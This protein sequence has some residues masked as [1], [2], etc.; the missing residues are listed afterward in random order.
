M[1]EPEGDLE[2]KVEQGGKRSFFNRIHGD[3][4][5]IVAAILLAMATVASAWSACQASRW[6]GVEAKKYN[7]ANARRVEASTYADDAEQEYGL[8]SDMFIYYSYELYNGNESAVKYFE[9]VLFRDEMRTAVLAWKKLKPWEN[10]EAPE[11]PMDMP[12]YKSDHEA[13]SLKLFGEADE[14][15]N[16]ARKAINHSDTYVTLTVLF[17]SVLFF[18]GISIKFKAPHLRIC[19]LFTGVTLFLVSVTVLATQP[20]T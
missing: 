12:E 18:A 15:A 17:A 10:P 16:A 8:D 4:V 7:D 9:D 19:L 2:D 14:L 3:W 5:E 13:K 11:T 6:H 1:T 20:V